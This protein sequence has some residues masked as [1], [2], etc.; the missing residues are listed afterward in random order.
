MPETLSVEP[1]R[2]VAATTSPATAFFAAFRDATSEVRFSM[3][4]EDAAE[5]GRVAAAFRSAG[6]GAE[7]WCLQSGWTREAARWLAQA[8]TL[9]AGGWLLHGSGDMNALERELG[10]AWRAFRESDLH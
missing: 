6:A 5:L 1:D 3:V 4:V 8:F 2:A 10:F 9:A 7:A